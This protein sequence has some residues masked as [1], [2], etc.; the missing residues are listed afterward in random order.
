MLDLWIEAHKFILNMQPGDC[1]LSASGNVSCI[2]R[3]ANRIYLSS[4]STITLKKCENLFYLNGK[5]VNQILRDIEGYMIYKIHS[6]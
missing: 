3:T 5:N 6:L 1:Y 4:G 2:K